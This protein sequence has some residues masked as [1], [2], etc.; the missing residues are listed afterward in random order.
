VNAPVEADAPVAPAPD[1]R[2]TP[3]APSEAT[4]SSQPASGSKATAPVSSKKESTTKRSLRSLQTVSLRPKADAPT[5]TETAQ[6]TS[7]APLL[8][9]PFSLE[10]LKRAWNIF[11]ASIQE[12]P[13]LTNALKSSP[14]NLLPDEVV[15]LV[16]QNQPVEM[17]VEHLRPSIEEHLRQQLKNHRIRLSL[18]LSEEDENV[19]PFTSR[20]KLDSM[21]KT[22]PNLE[23]LHRALGL[24]L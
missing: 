14:L 24:E 11:V 8:N 2:A 13:H 3:P 7:A 18:R 5:V 22:N 6:T 10:A 19:R 21:I 12:D 1:I 20:E 9:Q 4:P 23:L 16:V 15:E 17:K